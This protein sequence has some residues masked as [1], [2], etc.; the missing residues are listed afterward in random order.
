MARTGTAEAI[1]A[2]A[3]E[4]REGNAQLI[5]WLQQSSERQERQN[6][7]TIAALGEISKGQERIAQGQERITQMVTE[8]TKLLANMLLESQALT[9]RTLELTRD[10]HTHTTGGGSGT[11]H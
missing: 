11:S 7:A 5:A 2:L 6:Q 4:M 9:A 8:S 10:I 3:T 1:L